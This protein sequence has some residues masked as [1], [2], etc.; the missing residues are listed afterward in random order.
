MGTAETPAAPMHGLMRLP[1]GNSRFMPFA[2][3]M[4]PAVLATN[5]TAPS[6]RMNSVSGRRKLAPSIV[7]PTTSPSRIVTM[8]ISG[9]DAVLASRSVT[10]DSRSRLPNISRP[11]SGAAGGTASDTSTVI[12]IGNRITAVLD[13]VR[14]SGTGI[15]RSA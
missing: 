15:S 14:S 2:S 13:T 8:L 6:S 1:S 4:P 3:R 7:A 11:I 5:A 12:T 10:P 9:P